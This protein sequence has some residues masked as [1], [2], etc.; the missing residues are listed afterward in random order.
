MHL[1]GEKEAYL[2]GLLSEVLHEMTQL[3]GTIQ[4]HR[5][6]LSPARQLPNE[7]LERI[8]LLC[9]PEGSMVHRQLSHVCRRWRTFVHDTA[10]L[11][12][13]LTIPP[14]WIRQSRAQTAN[15]KKKLDFIEESLRRSGERQLTL[16]W[17]AD[18][19]LTRTEID[20]VTQMI[21]PHCHRWRELSLILRGVSQDSV[22]RALQGLAVSRIACLTSVCLVFGDT[23]LADAS[24]WLHSPLLNA[25]NLRSVHIS[26]LPY[27]LVTVHPDWSSLT[28]LSYFQPPVLGSGL[29]WS[30]FKAR[31]AYN[32]LRRCHQLVTCS[33]VIQDDDDPEALMSEIQSVDLPFLQSLEIFAHSRSIP[34]LFQ[35]FYAPALK[36]L[37]YIP[38][39]E[40][41]LHSRTPLLSLLASNG[42]QIQNLE[43]DVMAFTHADLVRSL[44]LTPLV[45]HVKSVNHPLQ[46]EFASPCINYVQAL[47][48]IL[49]PPVCDSLCPLLRDLDLG[50]L[51]DLRI[52]SGSGYAAPSTQ[53]LRDFLEARTNLTVNHLRRVAIP[54]TDSA[55]KDGLITLSKEFGVSIV[56]T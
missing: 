1:L 21:L 52:R 39:P 40:P 25:P 55:D 27:H 30:R 36:T 49:S 53:G 17:E 26:R 33:M 48:N 41:S 22:L 28:D 14:L 2:Q 32:V 8:F 38:Y 23:I 16:T 56:V 10:L 7:L 45:R 44:T 12:S 35:S 29:F 19:S 47:L 3:N 46:K 15:Q 4:Q 20:I 42:G 18:S 43:I 51:W 34:A 13:N 37:K 54:A 24:N 31:D 5:A 6:L 50:S 9:L 11:W